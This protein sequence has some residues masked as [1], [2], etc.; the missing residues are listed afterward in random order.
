MFPRGSSFG[1]NPV[2]FGEP[3][4]TIPFREGATMH[5]DEVETF[6]DTRSTG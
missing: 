6:Q 4:K 3:R 2:T 1:F 5:T